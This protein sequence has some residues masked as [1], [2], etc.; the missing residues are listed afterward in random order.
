MLEAKEAPLKL[1]HEDEAEL[2]DN[3]IP[4]DHYDLLNDQ[5]EHD[6]DIA[7]ED[8]EYYK[9][10]AS[11]LDEI[12]EGAILSNGQKVTY[13]YSK[14][15]DYAIYS[16]DSNPEAYWYWEFYDQDVS[17]AL[18]E[19]ERLIN[20]SHKRFKGISKPGITKVLTSTL[21]VIFQ[22]RNPEQISHA[23]QIFEQSI[24]DEPEIKSVVSRGVNHSVWINKL[25]NCGYSHK[26]LNNVSESENEFGRIQA[27]AKAM[28]PR[29]YNEKIQHRLA[30]AMSTAL[31]RNNGAEGVMAFQ[32]VDKL[33]HRLAE[34]K[35]KLHY[36]VATTLSAMLLTLAAWLMY[37][38][39]NLPDLI[40][41]SLVTIGGGFLGTL[42]SVLERSKEIR[43]NEYESSELIILQG[44]LRVC[45]GGAFG[46]IAFLAA[47]SGLAFSLFKE[48]MSMLILIGVAV[49][50]SERLIPDLI[51]GLASTKDHAS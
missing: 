11:K 14:G 36:I 42:I 33:I 17:R 28:L 47:T 23:L 24:E 30:V 1:S 3:L 4:P 2:I 9:K 7:D 31:R 48:T 22:S 45:L 29:E 49:G 8:L 32:S 37:E 5:E 27:L 18:L 6:Y 20:K 44:I 10:T 19:L 13:V 25:G 38:C 26:G 39:A 50:F 12:I 46:L 43:I 40:H 15:S 41:A 16:T 51:Q 34:N 21:R 35:L